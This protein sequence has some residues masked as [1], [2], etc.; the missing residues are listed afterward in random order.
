MAEQTIN[1]NQQPK[2]KNYK[3]AI[4]IG[5]GVAATAVGGFFG[6]KWLKGKDNVT[7]TENDADDA[8]G[9][10]DGSRHGWHGHHRSR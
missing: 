6:W 2:K 7:H 4:L 1:T 8:G 9:K 10:D 3:K 5:L